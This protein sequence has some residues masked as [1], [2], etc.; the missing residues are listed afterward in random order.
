MLGNIAKLLL[1]SEADNG[2]EI[3]GDSTSLGGKLNLNDTTAGIL[4]IVILVLATAVCVV[5]V[6]LK[7]KQYL[8]IV[9]NAL[10][11]KKREE[12]EQKREE[13]KLEKEVKEL[14]E[15]RFGASNDSKNIQPNSNNA[16]AINGSGATFSE[17]PANVEHSANAGTPPQRVVS[18]NVQMPENVVVPANA[19]N[20]TN[21]E[22]VANTQNSAN[23]VASGPTQNSASLGTFADIQNSTTA[24]N[25]Q[26]MQ[27]NQPVE[28][29]G[30]TQGA[31]DGQGLNNSSLGENGG[32]TFPKAFPKNL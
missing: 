3:V 11:E 5:W 9:E 27:S 28:T 2:F 22:T 8:K 24:S 10:D 16:S 18:T 30:I 21:A 20:L 7:R 23:V 13:E 6:L 19:Q 31:S 29:S 15:M 17:V 4:A 12:E 14:E 1:D 25:M 32:K 26:N